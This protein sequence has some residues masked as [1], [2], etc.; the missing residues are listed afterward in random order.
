MLN[1]LE[2]EICISSWAFYKEVYMTPPLLA[3]I[4]NKHSIFS[5]KHLKLGLSVIAS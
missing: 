5:N 2:R 4:L 1:Q 3:N